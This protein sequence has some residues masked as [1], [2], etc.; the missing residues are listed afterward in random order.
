MEE[1]KLREIRIPIK[2]LLVKMGIKFDDVKSVG[3]RK[4]TINHLDGFL[5]I[6]VSE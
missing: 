4:A 2:E 1:I 3:V 5:E 6:V